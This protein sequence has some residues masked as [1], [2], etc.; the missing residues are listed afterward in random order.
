MLRAKFAYDVRHVARVSCKCCAHQPREERATRDVAFGP[1]RIPY[2]CIAHKRVLLLATSVSSWDLL[3]QWSDL[4]KLPYTTG[5]T[6]SYSHWTFCWIYRLQA[7]TDKGQIQGVL[8]W[9]QVVPFTSQFYLPQNI[10]CHSGAVVWSSACHLSGPWVD[11]RGRLSFL[12]FPP[13]IF[14]KSPNVVYMH[15]EANNV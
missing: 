3:W 11:S 10:G 7:T 5:W 4:V 15:I 8:E 1:H 6:H 12:R 13:T 14:D 9:R 2:L